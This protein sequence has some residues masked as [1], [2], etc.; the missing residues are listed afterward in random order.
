MSPSVP[1]DLAHLLFWRATDLRV[2]T[3]PNILFG[4]PRCRQGP[5]DTLIRGNTF[6]SS[7]TLFAHASN[8]LYFIDCIQENHLSFANWG[9]LS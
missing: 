5:L 6:D 7:T 8:N 1:V 9:T 3:T 4:V 2:K